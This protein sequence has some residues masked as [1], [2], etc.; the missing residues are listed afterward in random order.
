MALDVPWIK[1]KYFR[2]HGLTILYDISK[3]K[4][5]FWMFVEAGR[6]APFSSDMR[7]RLRE[8]LLTE[9]TEWGFGF[10]REK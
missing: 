8:R 2:W 4:L 1:H 9:I 6:W 3:V 5:N 10:W 7:K